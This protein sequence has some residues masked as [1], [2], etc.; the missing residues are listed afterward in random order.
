MFDE[1]N[2]QSNVIISLLFLNVIAVKKKQIIHF[3]EVDF[4]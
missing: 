1:N 4:T 2:H 3:G